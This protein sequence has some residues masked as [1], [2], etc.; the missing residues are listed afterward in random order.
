MKLELKFD[1]NNITT[2]ALNNLFTNGWGYNGVELTN[3]SGIECTQEDIDAE[4]KR[5][6][7]EYDALEYA[8]NRATEYPAIADQLD[9]I[10]HNG[11]NAWKAVIKVTKDKYPKG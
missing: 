5:L 11:I 1:E 10:Y 8:R 4:V 7:A 2:Q 3:T 6:Q 9:E